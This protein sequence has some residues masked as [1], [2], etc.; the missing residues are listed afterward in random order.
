M[1]PYPLRR[2]PPQ[3]ARARYAGV[4]FSP[5]AHRVWQPGATPATFLRALVEA[6]LYPDALAVIAHTLPT[7][8]L[9]WWGTLCVRGLTSER[10]PPH[11][12]AN[13]DA[14]VRWVR[15]PSEANREA[16]RALAVAQPGRFGVRIVRAIA[17]SNVDPRKS[18]S[19]IL[20]AVTLAASRG[21]E[22]FRPDLCRQFIRFGIDIDRGAIAL[23]LPEGEHRG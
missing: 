1:T 21:E 17:I 15:D 18:T 4:Y 9:I 12:Q 11:G 7:R 20:E 14:V 8:L 16:A 2:T 3:P 13:F 6:E 5:A 23:P 22:G 10:L 19:L